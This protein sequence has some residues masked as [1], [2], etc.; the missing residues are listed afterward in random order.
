MRLNYKSLVL[1]VTLYSSNL[2]GQETFELIFESPYEERI[3]NIIE[4]YSGNFYGIGVQR[5]EDPHREYPVIWKIDYQGD[6]TSRV[7]LS[8]DTLSGFQ[9]IEPNLDGTLE[10]FGYQKYNS[11][12]NRNILYYKLNPN[13]DILDS[14]VISLPQYYSIAITEFLSAPGYYFFFCKLTSQDSI[15]KPGVIKLDK[16]LNYISSTVYDY[17]SY[18]YITEAFFSPDSSQ[19]WMYTE[20]FTPLKAVSPT[21]LFIIDILLNPVSLKPLPANQYSSFSYFDDYLA[22]GLIE[23]NNIL[24]GGTF[25][26]GTNQPFN[27]ELD[28]GVTICDT[29]MNQ[30]GLEIFGTIDTIDQSAAYDAVDFI[31]PDRFLFCGTL[32]VGDGFF[33]NHPTIIHVR[34]MDNELNTIYERNFGG[35]AF[36]YTTNI[37]ATSDGGCLIAAHR[38]ELGTDFLRNTYLLKLNSEGLLTSTHNEKIPLT[39]PYKFNIDSETRQIQ[40]DLLIDKATA[41]LYDINGSLLDIMALKKGCNVFSFNKVKNHRILIIKTN[42]DI[43][44][45][46]F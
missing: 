20:E 45:E 36:Y 26:H 5:R 22:G 3:G 29:S 21:H 43:F 11:N 27:T 41:Y 38:S 10:V 39:K 42:P 1:L 9:F 15:Q 32:K 23:N 28:I 19:I 24:I 17:S 7:Y 33:P 14:S 25:F 30:L 4:D 12:S 35:D 8:D 16:N 44:T 34:S 18:G 31:S 13:L 37:I 46:K 2:F 6:T 40:I